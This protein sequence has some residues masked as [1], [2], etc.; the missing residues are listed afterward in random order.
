MAKQ[1]LTIKDVLT[2]FDYT[3]NPILDKKVDKCEKCGKAFRT[4]SIE[5]VYYKICA[6]QRIKTKK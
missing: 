2:K 5:D 4:V 3:L 6:C 1:Q